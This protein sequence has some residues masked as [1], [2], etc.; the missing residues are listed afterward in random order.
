MDIAHAK[1]SYQFTVL[2]AE[3]ENMLLRTFGEH[4]AFNT[5]Q[6]NT[7]HIIAIQIAFFFFFLNKIHVSFS[8][9]STKSYLQVFFVCC[10][11]GLWDLHV[12]TPSPT[13]WLT[14]QSQSYFWWRQR[15]KN[16]C[17]KKQNLA[18]LTSIIQ[19]KNVHFFQSVTIIS[20]IV[21]KISLLSTLKKKKPASTC[22][23]T[24]KWLRIS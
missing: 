22:Q 12:V 17:N 23:Y 20:V 10:V 9:Q 18:F 2:P 19:I 14:F 16:K 24:A 8:F 1:F 21:T 15:S 7:F 3:Y 6:V 11:W 4:A 5:A 13:L